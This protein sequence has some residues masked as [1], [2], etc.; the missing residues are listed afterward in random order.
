[1][2]GGD[3]Q[4]EPTAI[5]IFGKE[6]ET[7]PQNAAQRQAG[8]KGEHVVEPVRIQQQQEA[9]ADETEYYAGGNGGF[10]APL[11]SVT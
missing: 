4:R 6:K 9:D 11:D 8:E 2:A 7:V 10:D 3:D 5:V 1:M